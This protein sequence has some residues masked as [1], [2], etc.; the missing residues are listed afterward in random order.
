MP[1]FWTML[2][3]VTT[4][5]NPCLQSS[6]TLTSGRSLEPQTRAL[7]WYH[8]LRRMKIEASLT[9]NITERVK[10]K[11]IVLL[12]FHQIIYKKC[13]YNAV[14]QHYFCNSVAITT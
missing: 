10:D 12:V 14:D 13:L 11:V 2:V 1:P 7:S 4:W 6:F 3:P 8:Y 9:V 5:N